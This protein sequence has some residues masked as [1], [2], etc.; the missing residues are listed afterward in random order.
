MARYWDMPRDLAHKVNADLLEVVTLLH[1]S[2][3]EAGACDGEADDERLTSP[4]S[5]AVA[6]ISMADN[7]VRGV[8]RA[9]APYV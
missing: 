1:V 6:L 2:R 8:L 5:R 4:S 9:I 7:K 3:R